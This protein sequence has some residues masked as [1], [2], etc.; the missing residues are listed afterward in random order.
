MHKSP[1]A[2][3]PS[4]KKRSA[5]KES[6][7]EPPVKKV[8]EATVSEEKCLS[9]DLQKELPF[10]PHFI[11]VNTEKEEKKPK[12]RVKAP[13]QKSKKQQKREDRKKK[14]VEEKK[15]KDVI[16]N[17]LIESHIKHSLKE[18]QLKA[19]QP[20]RLLGAGSETTKQELQRLA[21]YE[22][23][24]IKEQT[25]P[26]ADKF[27]QKRNPELV[28]QRWNEAGISLTPEEI[29]V[30][31]LET[32]SQTEEKEKMDETKVENVEEKKPLIVLD[33]FGSGQTI[34]NAPNATST[35]KKEEKEEKK[36]EEKESMFYEDDEDPT[37]G[38][39]IEDMGKTYNELIDNM[40]EKLD[41]SK[42]DEE[43]EIKFTR[44]YVTVNR[45][46]EI[47]ETR[48]LLPI[49]G[50]EQ[51]IMETINENEIVIVK[52]ETGSGKVGFYLKLNSNNVPDHTNTAIF[53]RVRLWMHRVRLSRFNWCHTTKKSSCSEYS[54]AC[55]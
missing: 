44:F 20:I 49:C 10:D 41:Q 9:K 22:Q 23:L 46:K 14:K 29:K 16:R 47:Q 39:N 4:A 25:V 43:K 40:I 8:K 18:D 7:S 53:V 38:L 34:N 28:E 19:L 51:R 27:W 5:S 15:V 13:P 55:C 17:Q 32:P 52:G 33:F 45:K 2:E 3:K 21:I 12:K 37:M 48:M 26:K 24:G 30:Q 31:G 6:S 50:E 1:T 36:E 42:T 11:E 54:Q 35:K